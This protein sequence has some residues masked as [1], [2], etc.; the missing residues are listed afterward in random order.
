MNIVWMDLKGK[1]LELRKVLDSWVSTD[2]AEETKGGGHTRGRV[3]GE[4]AGCKGRSVRRK[5]RQTDRKSRP[6]G[7]YLAKMIRPRTKRPGGSGPVRSVTETRTSGESGSRV[8]GRLV[9]LT[10]F[11]CNVCRQKR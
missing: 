1:T 4:D 2:G 10:S 3:G 11:Y 6:V 8:S 9:S 7:C 5:N